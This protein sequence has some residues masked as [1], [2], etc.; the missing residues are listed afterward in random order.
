[1]EKKRKRREK[2]KRKQWK[3]TKNN[4]CMVKDDSEE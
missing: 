3:K 4:I 1:M 2:G